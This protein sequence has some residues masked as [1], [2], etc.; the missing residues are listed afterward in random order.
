MR[1]LKKLGRDISFSNIST[2]RKVILA[3]ED[4]GVGV[5]S[6]VAL[7]IFLHLYLQSLWFLLHVQ[8]H[9]H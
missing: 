7:C 2:S 8:N 6:V 9:L 3:D 4:V 1:Q 5:E